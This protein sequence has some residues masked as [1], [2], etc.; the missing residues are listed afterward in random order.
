MFCSSP[1]PQPP[2]K[3][4]ALTWLIHL[5]A[6]LS[7]QPMPREPLL[8][9]APKS[10]CII[11]QSRHAPLKVLFRDKH[12]NAKSRRI[13]T[14]C[15]S[16]SLSLIFLV[17]GSTTPVQPVKDANHLRK[18]TEETRPAQD[19]KPVSLSYTT[20]INPPDCSCQWFVNV[21]LFSSS[22]PQ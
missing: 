5:F 12:I 17:L 22:P 8:T 3:G 21:L 14:Q 13:N 16:V 6:A 1:R 11:Q 19:D 2:S 9:A 10:P 18:Q 20:S 15:K 4:L 7:S